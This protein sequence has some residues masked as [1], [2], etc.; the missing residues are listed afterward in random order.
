MEDLPSGREGARKRKRDT[1]R[2]FECEESTN[3]EYFEEDL[4]FITVRHDY[5]HEVPVPKMSIT[6]D[7]AEKIRS[8]IDD[9]ILPYQIRNTISNSLL[10]KPT[11]AQVYYEWHKYIRSEFKYNK[12]PFTSSDHFTLVW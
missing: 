11:Y 5:L 1:Q 7:V 6:K 10:C 9:G 8:R 12:D 2:I 4:L 3:F